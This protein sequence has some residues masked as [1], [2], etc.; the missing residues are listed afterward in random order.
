MSAP[1]RGERTVVTPRLRLVRGNQRRTPDQG[2]CDRAAE[3]LRLL[4]CWTRA[5]ERLALIRLSNRV[6]RPR[7]GGIA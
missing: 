3:S 5:T 1:T 4:Q 6:T 7:T 2:K